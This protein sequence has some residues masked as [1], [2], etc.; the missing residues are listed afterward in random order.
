MGEVDDV[1]FELIELRVRVED[2]HCIPLTVFKL[3]TTPRRVARAERGNLGFGHIAVPDS[4][5]HEG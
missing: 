1:A 5:R 4:G 3:V 2:T